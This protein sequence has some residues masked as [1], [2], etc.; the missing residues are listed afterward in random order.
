VEAVCVWL[1]HWSPSTVY[2]IMAV[3]A[4]VGVISWF[5]PKKKRATSDPQRR[6]PA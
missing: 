1:F 2:T 3:I 4:V 5:I 6:V